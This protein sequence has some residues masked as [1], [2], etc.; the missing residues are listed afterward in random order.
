M[1]AVD[2]AR[3]IVARIA[4]QV[5]SEVAPEN[6]F[7][8]DTDSDPG[9]Y[10]GHNVVLPSQG[11][12]RATALLCAGATRVFIGEAAL[13]DADLIGAI[14]SKF[15]S[16]R[17]GLYV[18]SKRMQVSW[19]MD[20]ASNADFR[21]MTPSVCEPCWEILLADGRPTGARVHWWLREMF[22]LGAG[23][24][25]VRV[26]IADDADLN[27]CAE[28]IEDCGSKIWLG[29]LENDEVN[30]EDWV[31]YGKATHLAIPDTL[32]PTLTAWRTQSTAHESSERRV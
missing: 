13:K 7:V 21:F 32:Y 22:R 28:L 18:P 8:F 6:L 15:G 31:I 10:T 2:S 17:T 16:A 4:E 3:V 25:L 14:A 12:A 23:M 9:D 11:L 30:I 27:L 1:P 20:T 19:S 24:A 29:P 5:P 26:D